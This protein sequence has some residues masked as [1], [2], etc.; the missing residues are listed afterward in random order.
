MTFFIRTILLF[1]LITPASL[2]LAHGDHNVID[3]DTAVQIAHKTVQRM[4]FKDVG[5]KA[6]K[7]DASWKS[8]KPENIKVVKVEN[9]FYLLSVSQGEKK[10]SLAMKIAFNGHVQEVTKTPAK[11][12]E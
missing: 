11:V 12:S 3:Q 4:T 6:G 5:Y 8:I 2:V 9:G 1:T 7:L 10:P